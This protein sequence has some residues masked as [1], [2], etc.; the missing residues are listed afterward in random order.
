MRIGAE[1]KLK[2]RASCSVNITKKKTTTRN[3]F[4]NNSEGGDKNT[5]TTGQCL[6]NLVPFLFLPNDSFVSLGAV[7]VRAFIRVASFVRTTQSL[8][9]GGGDRQAY[10]SG[11]RHQPGRSMSTSS[12]SAWSGGRAL[13]RRKPGSVG[14]ASG[15]CFG[16]SAPSWKP[17]R[18]LGVAAAVVVTL[19]SCS[20]TLLLSRI[21]S[22]AL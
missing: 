13:P 11:G 14:F 8:G 21:D 1:T 19:A 18:S 10:D 16:V 12:S 17:R 6:R 2:A 7:N 9:G 4:Q 22:A 20:V 3:D 15:Q 5:H